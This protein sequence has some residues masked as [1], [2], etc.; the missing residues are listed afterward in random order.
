MT[1]DQGAGECEM[2]HGR[3]HQIR[4]PIKMK[5]ADLSPRPIVAISLAASH[6]R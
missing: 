6:E 1:T 5:G 4:H 3:E 2:G